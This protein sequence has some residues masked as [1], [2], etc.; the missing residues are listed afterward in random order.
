MTIWVEAFSLEPDTG[1]VMDFG[2][3][4]GIKTWLEEKFDHTLLLDERDPL[5]PVFKLL[6]AEGACKLVVLPDV[7][8]E[9]SAKFVFDYVSRDVALKTSGRVWV[10][11]VEMR[12]NDKNSAIYVAP[13]APTTAEE[14]LCK[15]LSDDVISRR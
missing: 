4:K 10:C 11:S 15:Y 12:E 13:S 7:G 9:G 5:L 3:L 8:M 6:E 1:F 14:N 2:S